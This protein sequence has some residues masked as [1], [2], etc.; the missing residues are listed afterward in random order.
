MVAVGWTLEAHDENPDPDC[1]RCRECPGAPIGGD[2]R[3]ELSRPADGAIGG[4]DRFAG[5][6]GEGAGRAYGGIGS[7][8]TRA[9]ARSLMRC[10]RPTREARIKG[11]QA[12]SERA[13]AR[14]AEL[15]PVLTKLQASGITSPRALATAL[16]AR[17]IPTPSRRGPWSDTVVRRV[18]KR[19][20]RLEDAAS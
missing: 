10:G 7:R 6:D 4:V 12:H 20:K 14:A 15:A 5:R 1:C 17:N 19:I 8:S 18:L 3:C 13:D 2:H 11:N 16:T 9:R